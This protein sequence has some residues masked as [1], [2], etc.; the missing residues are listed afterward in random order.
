MIATC[1]ADNADA[2]R[3][4]QRARRIAREIQRLERMRRLGI[5]TGPDL[6]ERIAQLEERHRRA[7]ERAAALSWC[8]DPIN[9]KAPSPISGLADVPTDQS[10]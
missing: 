1:R 5:L 4:A 8:Q 6:D 9:V 3:Q 7:I 10:R 2:E